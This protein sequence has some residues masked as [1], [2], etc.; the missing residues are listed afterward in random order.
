VRLE[1]SQRWCIV[2]ILYAFVPLARG[3][4]RAHRAPPYDPFSG[5]V[6]P[7]LRLLLPT[8]GHH[9]QRTI[10]HSLVPNNVCTQLGPPWAISGLASLRSYAAMSQMHQPLLLRAPHDVGDER[11]GCQT[12]ICTRK[13]YS[14]SQ[15]HE[16]RQTGSLHAPSPRAHGGESRRW[17]YSGWVNRH[18]G[19]EHE[20]RTAELSNI[21]PKPHHL[22]TLDELCEEAMVPWPCASAQSTQTWYPW[23]RHVLLKAGTMVGTAQ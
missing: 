22:R 11:L 2:K 18:N 1:P 15:S 21:D 12:S 16:T 9:D 23:A 8:T 17:T 7:R 5:S 10:A 13:F 6:A 3:R 14:G 4:P 20:T 19:I